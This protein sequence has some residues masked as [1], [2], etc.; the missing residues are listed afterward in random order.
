MHYSVLKRAVTSP[1]T[2]I[3][4]SIMK[5]DLDVL[6][7]YAP[8]GIPIIWISSKKLC[9]SIRADVWGKGNTG[10]AFFCIEFNFVTPVFLFIILHNDVHFP[11]IIFAIKIQVQRHAFDLSFFI[12]F[13]HN[14][15][16]KNTAII[17]AQ[18]KGAKIPNQCVAN[19]QIVKI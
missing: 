6:M 10:N 2:I 11:A 14:E 18:V 16:F 9:P 12:Q 19:S 4:L 1:S 17:R 3:A 13:S 8:L 5:V 15:I 7:D